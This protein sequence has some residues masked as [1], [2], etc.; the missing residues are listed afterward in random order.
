MKIDNSR[1]ESGTFL[2]DFCAIRS[3][4]LVV[5]I[6][7]LLA[8]VL[9]LAGSGPL[10]GRLDDLAFNS[11]FVQW[12]ALVCTALLCASRPWLARFPDST[13]AV[14]AYGAMLMVTWALSEIAWWITQSEISILVAATHGELL[15]R[16]LGI[17]AIV[18]AVVLRYFYV[19]NLWQRRVRSESLARFQALQ[20]R[21]RPHFFFNCMNTIASLTRSSPAAAEKAVE[22]LA[23]LFRASLSDARD[24]VPLDE[25]LNLCRQYLDIEKLRLGDRLQLD[26]DTAA[27][28]QD[29]QLPALTLQPLLEN[30]IYHGIEPQPAGGIILLR[31]RTL[32]GRIELSIENPITADRSRRHDGNRLAQENVRQRLAAVYGTAA[33]LQVEAGTDRY[34]VTLIIPYRTG[35]NDEDPDR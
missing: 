11:L 2:P 16:T 25:E 28:P 19:Q 15:L 9:T 7:E 31:G 10:R 14:I 23:D 35:H 1:D 20:A 29:A 33:G 22:D 18:S 21:I 3:V 34:R 17:S 12:V 32:D 26:W 4:F 30:A 5:L 8:L 24:Q 6:A 27:V 13:V